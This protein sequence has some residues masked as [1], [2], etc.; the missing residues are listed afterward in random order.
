MKIAVIGNQFI[1]HEVMETELRKNFPE[2]EIVGYSTGWPLDLR[3]AVAKSD[4]EI[5]EYDGKEDDVITVAEGADYLVTDIGPVSSKV[6]EALPT[7]KAVA[8][9]RGGTLNVNVSEMT[10]RGIPLFNSPGRNLTAVAEFTLAMALAHLKNIPIANHDLHNGI[11]RSDFYSADKVGREITEIR[12][13]IIGFGNIGRQVAHNF[14]SL[15]SEVAVFDPFVPEDVI[16]GQ[17]YIPVTLNELCESSDV[18]TV[19]AKVMDSNHHLIGK[20][21][22]GM[23]KKNALLVN[24]A[25]AELIDMDALYVALSEHKIGGAALDVYEQEPLKPGSRYF[26]LDNL[27]MTPHIGG[28]SQATI[29]CALERAIGDL[30]R[31]HNE[32]T[33]LYCLN[34]EVLKETR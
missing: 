28:A 29:R 14:K 25:R 21:Q 22:I 23:M 30:V 2:A 19:H 4:G 15:G 5:S 32:E 34:P 10:K 20:E 7:L 16:R 3:Q 8:A 12:V 1:R 17:G 24:T 26:E 31:F 13:G 9:T 27:T 11:W 6:L 33:P 18:V